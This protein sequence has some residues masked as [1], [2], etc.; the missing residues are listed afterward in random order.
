MRIR[1]A[2]LVVALAT[3][4]FVAAACNSADG[5]PSA[6]LP[7]DGPTLSDPSGADNLDSRIL[8]TSSWSTDFGT[9]SVDLSEFLSGGPAKDGIRALEAPGFVS[10]QEGDESF[11][12]REPV[13]ALEL[14]GDARAYPLGILTRHEIANDTV[15][16]VPVAVTFCPLCNSAIVF[17]R[18][19]D[20]VVYDFGVSGVLRNSDLVMYDRQTESWWQQFIGEAIVGELTGALLD[21]A[22][23]SIVSWADFKAGYPDGTVLSTDT[24]FGY[25]YGFNPYINYD[26]DETPFLFRGEPDD[27]LSLIERVAGVE[28]NG[29]A[30]A[31]PFELLGENR[32]IHDT[33]G[34]DEIVVFFQFGTASALDDSEIHRGRD[35]GAAGVFVPQAGGNALT[36]ARDGD[37]IV[38]TETGSKWTILGRA[39]SGPLA[40]EQLTPVI[41]GSH[42]WFAWAA[43]KPDTRIFGG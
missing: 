18:T 35:V 36:F 17:E 1:R 41:H 19:L 43:F 6:T 39:I 38:D 20:G 12:D 33:V 27:R 26:S 4:A 3:L 22:P 24:G 25:N 14:N 34:G 13:I 11:E 9:H 28:L 42:F 32:V 21:V 23:S 37:E 15:G 16:G 2:H 30:V 10:I 5:D 7:G 8:A 31:Y 40:G 29:D